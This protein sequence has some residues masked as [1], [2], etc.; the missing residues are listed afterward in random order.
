MHLEIDHQDEE[1]KLFILFGDSRGKQEFLQHFLLP[2]KLFTSQILVLQY[3]FHQ[4]IFETE[5]EF[6]QELYRLV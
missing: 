6:Q 5:S 2:L 4:K 1:D 3:F